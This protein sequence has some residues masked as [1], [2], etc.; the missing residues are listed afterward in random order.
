MRLGKPCAVRTENKITEGSDLKKAF[1]IIIGL[2]LCTLAVFFV[3]KKAVNGGLRS[4]HA[5]TPQAAV[6]AE[7]GSSPTALLC[8]PVMLTASD[9]EFCVLVYPDEKE[10]FCVTFTEKKN[11]KYAYIYQYTFSADEITDGFGLTAFDVYRSCDAVFGIMPDGHDTVVVNGSI[12]SETVRFSFSGKT[13]R[14]WY[15]SV[16]GGIDAVGKI[17]YSK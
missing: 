2:V 11:G 12:H 8:E 5:E 3:G 15:A 1:V 16:D 10:E 17:E 6:A 7:F 14:L 4:Y 9:K 13:F